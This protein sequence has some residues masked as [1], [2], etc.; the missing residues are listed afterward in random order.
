MG[1]LPWPLKINLLSIRMGDTLFREWT[2]A[3]MHAPDA[4]DIACLKIII[5][6]NFNCI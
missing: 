1:K 5:K 3:Y 6:Q 2:L 4:V